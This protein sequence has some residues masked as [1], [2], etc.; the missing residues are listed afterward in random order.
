MAPRVVVAAN[1]NPEHSF[2]VR[3]KEWVRYACIAILA[4]FAWGVYE[5]GSGALVVLASM[6]VL[7]LIATFKDD[8]EAVALEASA[9]VPDAA[10]EVDGES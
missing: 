7:I 6:F 5:V 1:A 2:N 3:S 9:A 4:V 10:E 8:E